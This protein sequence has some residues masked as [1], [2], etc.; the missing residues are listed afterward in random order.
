MSLPVTILPQ[1][2][3]S[4]TIVRL[5][6]SKSLSNRALVI[7]AL[8]G[9][10]GQVE[11][12]SEAHDTVLMQRL[13]HT[14]DEVIDVE[15]AGT[16]MRF[17]TAYC[18]ITGRKC[19]LTGTARMQKRPIHELVQ[20][21][22]KLGAHIDYAAAEGYPPLRLGG[23]GSQQ[24]DTLSIRGDI[25]SQ[26]IS[27]LMMIA[28]L[29]PQ[30]LTLSLTGKVASRPYLEMTAAL[31]RHFGAAVTVEKGIVRVEPGSYGATSYTVE[32]DWSAASYWLS[33]AALAEQSDFLL[34]RLGGQSLQGDRVIVRIMKDLGVIATFRPEGLHLKSGGARVSELTVDFSECPDLAQTVLPACA[35]LGVTGSFSGMESLRIKETDR[36]AALQRELG[37]IGARLAEDGDRWQL[38][39]GDSGLPAVLEFDTYED[40][41]MAM[42]FAPLATRTKVVIHDPHVVKKSYPGFWED[43]KSVGFSLEA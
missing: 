3:L 18:G 11:N 35:T 1:P 16:V 17:L 20:A 25:S 24:T 19:I 31:M 10:P 8:T 2:R 30:G 34:P 21:L 12:L 38:T 5:P 13:L 26:F 29:L 43:V 32:A 15:D 37:K 22:R 4:G 27:A 23:F 33:F 14:P 7:Q 42:G 9:K 40:H 39:P 36:I 6:S 41:R 28:P